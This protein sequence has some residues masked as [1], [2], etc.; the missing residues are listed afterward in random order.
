MVEALPGAAVVL[1]PESATFSALSLSPLADVPDV[2]FIFIL[3]FIVSTISCG[4]TNSLSGTNK[5]EVD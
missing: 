5:V 1:F 3:Y 2:G 4:E